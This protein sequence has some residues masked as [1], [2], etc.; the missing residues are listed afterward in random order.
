MMVMRALF[1]MCI[2][3]VVLI[4]PGGNEDRRGDAVR[5]FSAEIRAVLEDQGMETFPHRGTLENGLAS[6]VVWFAPEGCSEQAAAMPVY[7]S[8]DLDA[9][10]SVNDVLGW[11]VEMHHIGQ[12]GSDLG[13]V[14]LVM[15]AGWARLQSALGLAEVRGPMHQIAVAVPD[16]CPAAR[17]VDL[18]PVWRD[19]A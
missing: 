3:L 12:S 6:Q 9:I 17:D 18:R 4:R 8:Q 1:A 2:G 15:R 19:A 10:L 11:E 13:R 5:A 16:A 14:G 7:I